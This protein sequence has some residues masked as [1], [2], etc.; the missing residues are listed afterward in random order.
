MAAVDFMHF[1][2]CFRCAYCGFVV[3]CCRN[4]K[5]SWSARSG[6]LREW[7]RGDDPVVHQHIELK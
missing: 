7:E 2:D 3:C 4:P 6:A 1:G 5:D